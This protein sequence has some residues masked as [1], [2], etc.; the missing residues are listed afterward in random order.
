MV[1]DLPYRSNYT[2]YVF[3]EDKSISCRF[4]YCDGTKAIND[5]RELKYNKLNH[6]G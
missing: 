3:N 2:T 5:L 4:T 6:S 1:T